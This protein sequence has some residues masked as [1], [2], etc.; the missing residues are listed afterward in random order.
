MRKLFALLALVFVP[1]AAAA[2]QSVRPAASPTPPENEDVV[3]IST[4]L[5]QVDVTVTDRK[6][7]VV[8]DLK[9]EDFEIYE[10]GEKQKISNFSFV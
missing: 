4:S 9:P 8:R 3:K 7:K 1:A 5:V 6:G 10:N 2:A